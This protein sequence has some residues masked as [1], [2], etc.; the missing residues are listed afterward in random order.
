MAPKVMSVWQAAL[1]VYLEPIGFSIL[2]AIPVV[3]DPATFQAGHAP[4]NQ[5]PSS[6]TLA[7]RVVL[8]QYAALLVV[9]GLSSTLVMHTALHLDD[10]TGRS[11]RRLIAA[12]QVALMLGDWLFASASIVPYFEAGLID[13]LNP[14]K[15]FTGQTPYLMA[16]FLGVWLSAALTC[17]RIAWLSGVGQQRITEKKNQ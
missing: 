6:L 5:A 17:M 7:N 11:Q 15:V 4:A 14:F 10:P 16:P 1:L 3:M 9:V 12:M 13:Y 2:G 8:Y